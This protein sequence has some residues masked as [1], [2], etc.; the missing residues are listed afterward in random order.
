[1]TPH[2]QRS[3]QLKECWQSIIFGVCIGIVF[4]F[5][6]FYVEWRIV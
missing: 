2:P 5:M 1:M 4:I 3:S 6:I